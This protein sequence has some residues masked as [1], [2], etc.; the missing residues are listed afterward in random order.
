MIWII[1]KEKAKVKK[2]KEGGKER[3]SYQ[4]PEFE[5]IVKKRED[6]KLYC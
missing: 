6:L 5:K 1:E 2:K 3:N 4:T